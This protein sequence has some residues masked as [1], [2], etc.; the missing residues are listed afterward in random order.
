MK[1]KNAEKTL[2]PTLLKAIQDK[3]Y[4]LGTTE[5]EIFNNVMSKNWNFES[6]QRGGS[7][8]IPLLAASVGLLTTKS[9]LRKKLFDW[10]HEYFNRAHTKFMEKEPLSRIYWNWMVIP[11]AV[12]YCWS[13]DRGS[14]GLANKSRLW[15][16]AWWS[17]C[18]LCSGWGPQALEHGFHPNNRRFGLAVAMCG[19][20][21]FSRSK[22]N[23]IRV[24]PPHHLEA[25]V[26]DSQFA[27]AIVWPGAKI[28]QN[29]W[30][31]DAFRG[32][33][34]R[35]Y[36]LDPY[37]LSLRE[38]R[39][40]RSHVKNGTESR[41]IIPF[42]ESHLPR[43][44]FR[45]F[46]TEKGV[47]SLMLRG[48]NTNTAPLYA[49]TWRD[50]GHTGWLHADPGDRK[51]IVLGVA[52]REGNKLFCS[53]GDTIIEAKCSGEFESIP[54]P[55]GKLLYCVSVSAEGARVA[56]FRPIVGEL[57][58]RFNILRG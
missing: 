57:E 50:D 24:G 38:A 10:W 49:A 43:V 51:D 4:K 13:A 55:P 29:G 2:A 34:K 27:R 37:G 17:Y 35:Y 8:N 32:L 20:R 5:R 22:V 41:Q 42:I 48:T 54:M 19:A 23:G 21:S 25:N 58:N 44:P 9:P 40:L 45:F 26:I 31:W 15:L 46:R 14:D 28:R 12:V 1:K 52:W 56:E 53:R 36:D 16:R 47:A 7:S 6:I 18:A 30:A 3:N 33:G 11:V 39:L